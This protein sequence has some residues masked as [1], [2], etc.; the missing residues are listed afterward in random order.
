M[1]VG[2]I[3]GFVASRVAESQLV[4]LKNHICRQKMESLSKQVSDTTDAASD[5]AMAI[6]ALFIRIPAVIQAFELAHSGD[7]KDASDEKG[8]PIRE[9][10]HKELKSLTEDYSEI[11]E[12]KK[13]R[14]NFHLPDGRSLLRVRLEKQSVQN[15]IWEDISDDIPDSRNT[16]TDAN[17]TDQS[18]RGIELGP[19]GFVISAVVPVKSPDGKQ[20]GTVEVLTDFNQ[21]LEKTVGKSET[22]SLSVFMNAENLPVTTLLQDAEKYPVIE[23]RHV[24]ITGTSENRE[25]HL[26]DAE[27][28]DRGRK[29]SFILMGE[30]S[31]LGVSPIK[32]SGSAQ[33]GVMVCAI[34]TA[35]EEY[36]IRNVMLTL[37]ACLFLMLIILGFSSFMAFSAFVTTPLGEIVS[38]SEEVALGNF[39]R[40]LA[41]GKK[42]EVGEVLSAVDRMV[43]KFGEIAAA[44][45][46]RGGLLC[47]ASEQMS[48]NISSVASSVWE[49]S[50]NLQ[51]VSRTAEEM[52][53]G[54][55]NVA[56][57]IEEM[58]VSVNEVRKNA[59]QGVTI[60][61]EAVDMAAKAGDAMTVL[62]EAANEIGE[63]TA[64]I[65]KVAD[66]TTLLALNAAIEAASAGEAGRGFAVVAN[67]IK[68][69]GCQS[70]LAADNI[71]R[72]IS[73]MQENTRQAIGII[74]DASGI[75]DEMNR[76]SE[77]IS[78]VLEEQM[79]AI[80]EIADNAAKANT[81][82]DDISNIMENLSEG[83][84]KV[85]ARMGGIGQSEDHGEESASM[86]V[87]AAEV[88]KL[89]HELL[90]LVEKF[91]MGK[92]NGES[93]EI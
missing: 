85:S 52:V 56:S 60:A 4:R 31:V 10:L 82:A 39:S 14:L 81:R 48:G 87:S 44:V 47:L 27:L 18:V 55:T 91:K 38:F 54:N 13:L 75:V 69:F 2:V 37:I 62:G 68:E 92:Q 43:L 50:I 25:P 35:Y 61:G 64:V 70:T 89:A 76:S 7:I 67:E 90:D 16:A 93:Q 19:E 84:S 57:A 21:I 28:L 80:D 15:G 41:P 46:S 3:L 45:K 1:I 30:E 22:D 86:E 73:V 40:T 24:Y 78:F 11:M 83:L 8:Q 65:K 58:S 42:D 9:M 32:D 88:A 6:S 74:R 51:N 26:T 17:R 49:I 72:R 63:V 53:L 79:R 34:K 20:L 77:N 29:E 59:Q 12:G 71:A 33:I 5:R 66:K 36:L 23:N